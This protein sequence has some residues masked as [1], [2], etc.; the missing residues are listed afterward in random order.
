MQNTELQH[1]LPEDADLQVVAALFRAK[2]PRGHLGQEAQALRER[3]RK[4]PELMAALRKRG[5][6]QLDP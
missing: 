3:Y 5:L 6:L 2:L 1:V 4:D